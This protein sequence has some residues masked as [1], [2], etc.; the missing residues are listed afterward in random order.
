M[1]LS[2]IGTRQIFRKWRSPEVGVRHAVAQIVKRGLALQGYR[3]AT[4]AGLGEM[5]FETLLISA[6]SAAVSLLNRTTASGGY[7]QEI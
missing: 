3:P 1:V 5:N 4:V 2:H 7:V 6:G